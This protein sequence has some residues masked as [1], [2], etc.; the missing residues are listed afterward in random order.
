MYQKLSRYGT[1][2]D[3]YVSNH[4]RSMNLKRSK[5]AIPPY[6]SK[7]T[8]TKQ[9][10]ERYFEYLTKSKLIKDIPE[11]V[12][13]ILGCWCDKKEDCHVRVLQEQIKNYLNL[14]PSDQSNLN[15][16]IIISRGS[17]RSKFSSYVRDKCFKS[18][19]SKKSR[20]P[21]ETDMA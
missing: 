11:L 21:T 19:F 4:Q 5:W 6:I 10:Q 12:G 8:N 13:Q 3:L 7:L 16:K 20:E 15:P 9:Q 17:K 18:C 1:G 2:C 14:K